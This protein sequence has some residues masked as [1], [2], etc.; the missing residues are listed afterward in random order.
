MMQ[1]QPH[2]AGARAV[3]TDR[4][5]M[6]LDFHPGKPVAAQCPIQLITRLW[7]RFPPQAAMIR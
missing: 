2:A 1:V 6:V 3:P 7:A 5:E 4:L